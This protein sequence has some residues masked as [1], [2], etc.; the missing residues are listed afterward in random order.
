MRIFE[1]S[2]LDLILG[3]ILHFHGLILSCSKEEGG[4]K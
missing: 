4:M 2:A 1:T 3:Y